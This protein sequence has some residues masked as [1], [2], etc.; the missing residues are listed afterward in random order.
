MDQAAVRYDRD[1]DQ[2]YDV[3]SAFIKSHPGLRRRRRPALPRADDRR[4]GGPRFI[5]RRLVVHASEDIG[6]ADPTA[7]QT[8]TAAAQAVQLIGMPE[9]KLDTRAGDDPP[10]DRAE[11]WG[12]RRRHRG[13]DGRRRRGQGGRG[14]SA[15]AR[16]ALRGR[17]ASGQRLSAP[18]PPWVTDTRTTTRT[19]LL[20][21][22]YPP[23]ELVGVDYYEPTQHGAEREVAVRIG[24]LR[25]IVRGAPDP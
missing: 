20:P 7:L 6:M 5:A 25:R 10:G 15:S 16:R 21:Q 2:H 18:A 4:G 8:A 9:A 3:I 24:K 1:G 14:P 12:R 11:I 23:N 19:A 22:Q 13:G 17:R